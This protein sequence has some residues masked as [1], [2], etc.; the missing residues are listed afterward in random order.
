MN[1]DKGSV[2]AEVAIIGAGFGGLGLAIRMQQQG[3]HD[4]VIYER[5]ND[6]GGVWRDN[7]YPGAACDVPSHLYSFS[8]EPN[9]DWGRTFGPQREI[10]RYLSHCA[11]KHKLREKIRF[12]TTVSEMAFCDSSGLWDL[13]FSDGSSRQAR[14]VVLAIGALN[15]PQYPEIEGLDQFLGKVMHTAEWDQDFSLKDKRVAVIGTGASAIQ[16]IPSIQPEVETLHVFQRTPPW[17]MPKF[18]KPLSAARQRLYRRWPLIQKIVRRFQYMLAESVVPAFMWDSFLT[19]FGEALGR[20]YLR[21]V[22]GNPTLRDKLTPKYAMGCKRVLLSDE[23]YPS[24]IKNNVKVCVEGISKVDESAICTGDGKRHEVDAI[25]FATGFKVPVSGAP[26]PIRGLDGRLLEKDW[27]VGSEAY[28][29]ITVSGY[30]NLLYVMGPNTGPGNTSV[31]FYIESQINYILK[32]LK[33]LRRTS[34]VYFD[35]KP[36]VQSEF[37]ADIQERF[38]GTTWTS[39]CNSWYLTK[40]GKN[41]TLWPSFSWQYRLATRHFSAAEYKHISVSNCVVEDIDINAVAAS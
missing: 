6:V 15:V 24:L 37:N 8:F 13:T 5:A 25:V 39:G 7:V 3:L 20:R 10:H 33:T 18:D 23:Y 16:V 41:T 2:V 29:G 36:M 28:K 26:M 19:R 34:N 21:K 1:N 14:A 32:Y 38:K 11:D 9:P 30:P 31:I 12:N 35:L 27:E 17:V 4:F 22:V 40:D